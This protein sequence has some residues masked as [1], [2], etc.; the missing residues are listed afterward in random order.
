MMVSRF[1]F[2]RPL[3]ALPLAALILVGL[4]GCQSQGGGFRPIDLL[5]PSP[6]SAERVMPEERSAASEE[7][8]K[9]QEEEHQRQERDADRIGRI[10]RE[11]EARQL[12]AARQAAAAERLALQ[13]QMKREIAAAKRQ[14]EEKARAEEEEKARARAEA[15]ARAEAEAQERTRRLAEERRRAEAAAKARR[16]EE[17]RQAQRKEAA[18][19]LAEKGERLLQEIAQA[20]EQGELEQG[21]AAMN[22]YQNLLGERALRESRFQHYREQLGAMK[23]AQIELEQARMAERYQEMQQQIA[24]HL[25][26]AG[27]LERSGQLQQARTRYQQILKLDAT[28]SVALESEQRLTQKIEMAREAATTAVEQKEVEPVKQEEVPAKSSLLG[29]E[30][31]GW[32]VQVDTY[33]GENKKEAYNLMGT[34][35]RAGVSAVFIKK[36]SFADTSFYRV[37]IGAY[38]ERAEAES[39][40]ADLQSLLDQQGV[41]VTPRVMQQ[42]H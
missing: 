21:E 40:M 29:S 17:E 10:D 31:D 39:V 23:A 15:K 22:R 3:Q 8:I 6:P 37:R 42:K 4:S 16:E 32:V 34:I 36:Q 7:P 5:R 11:E 1:M 2:S 13:Q 33:S 19:I 26:Q 25:L 9:E 14:A 20:M 18:R 28:H 41:V 27:S 35:K 30:D 12:E 24:D 38:G